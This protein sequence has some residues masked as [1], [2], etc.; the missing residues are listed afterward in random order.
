MDKRP[1]GI[2][3]SGLGGLSAVKAVLKYLPEEDII[4]FGDTQRVPYGSRSE[5]T[6]EAYAKDDI[7]FLE[8]FNCKLI[9]AACGTVSS[10]AVNA[11]SG[12]KEL[13]VGVVKPAAAAAVNATKNNKIG[14]MAT[15]AT[16]NSGAYTKEIKALEPKAEV[17][18]VSCPVLVTLVENNWIDT[19]DYISREIIRRYIDPLLKDG[20]DTIILGCTHFPHLAPIIQSVAGSGVKLIDNG[21]EAVM[22]AKK[23]LEES[24]LTNEKG[25]KG[26]A[27]YY[28]SDKTQNFSMI[29]KT[30][31]GIDISDKVT[32][33]E[34]TEKF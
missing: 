32:F 5:K 2:F 6:I 7:A 28:I 29:A 8:Q 33:K 1:I 34:L 10:V 25:R 31:L 24:S 16:I 19:D 21:F 26:T 23:I 14:V 13:F 20:V 30:L 9:M 18:G 27:Q 3:D 11:T 17:F 12:I 4:Y 22:Q 15:W